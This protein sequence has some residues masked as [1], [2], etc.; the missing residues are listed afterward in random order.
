MKREDFEEL[1]RLLRAWLEIAKDEED[2]LR[3]PESFEA[4]GKT[5][6]ERWL[7]V[8][9]Q[10]RRWVTAHPPERI[11]AISDRVVMRLGRHLKD[12][13]GSVTS[14]IPAYD[15]NSFATAIDAL[16]F[17]AELICTNAKELEVGFTDVDGACIPGLGSLHGIEERLPWFAKRLGEEVALLDAVPNSTPAALPENRQVGLTKTEIGKRQKKTFDH[18]ANGDQIKP[19][20]TLRDAADRS[21]ELAEKS[22]GEFLSFN[23]DT[24]SRY[25]KERWP[26][27]FKGESD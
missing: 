9:E 3:N 11:Q 4:S 14:L 10:L 13:F 24:A 23:K 22:P 19:G 8:R 12:D 6:Q 1:V 26:E 25:M 20:T 5:P 2:G 17:T 7:E 18:L 27:Y 16:Q 21:K 15:G